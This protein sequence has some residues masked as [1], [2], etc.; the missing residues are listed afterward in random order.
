MSVNEKEVSAFVDKIADAINDSPMD[1]DACMDVLG[2]II[3]DYVMT[4]DM[5]VDGFIRKLMSIQ[6][7]MEQKDDGRVH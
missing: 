4:Y 1:I 2:R 6:S 3:I 5:R 7:F